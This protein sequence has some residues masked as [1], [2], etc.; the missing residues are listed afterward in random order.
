MRAIC[1]RQ[2][3]AWLIV[4]GFKTIENRTW[5]TERRGEVL[6]HA[7]KNLTLKSYVEIKNLIC[8]HPDIV[9]IADLIPPMAELETGG[10]VGAVT[11]TDC[12]TQSDSPWF[13]NTGYGFVL[14]GGRALP[15]MACTGALNFFEVP[16]TQ[17][18]PTIAH[19]EPRKPD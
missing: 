11:I 8:Q 13:L 18:Q 19:H 9:G 7:S 3:W 6:V 4:N 1:I 16:A 17:Y 2:P 15:F 10:I 5:K 14:S 12:V